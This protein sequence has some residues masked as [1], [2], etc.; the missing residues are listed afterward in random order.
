M[1]LDN[2]TTHETYFNNNWIKCGRILL[3]KKDKQQIV[4]EKK[5]TDLH[6]NAYQNI[7]RIQFPHVGGLHNTLLLH[8][9]SLILEDY[10]QSLQIIHIQDRFHCWA[11]LQVVGEDV[12]LYDSLFITASAET[13]KI[14]AQLIQSKK[15]TIKMMNIQKQTNTVDCGLYA[16]AVL[17]SL[18][19]GQDEFTFNKSARNKCNFIISNFTNQ[20]ACYTC[21]QNRKMF[22]LLY[23]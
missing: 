15:F 14:V 4:N 18:L 5:L 23:L 9:T 12:Y 21:S 19:L 22:C 11:L 2:K 7:A 8:K 17:T 10:E 3:T 13:F 16:I 1:S 6:I 20:E